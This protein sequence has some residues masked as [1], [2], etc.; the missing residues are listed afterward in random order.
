MLPANP[1]I[2]AEKALRSSFSEFCAINPLYI[3]TEFDFVRKRCDWRYPGNADP[4]V[5]AAW[6]PFANDEI[7]SAM[8][9]SISACA[10]KI[11]AAIT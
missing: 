4:F 6:T 8:K 9:F 5:T 7:I 10:K 2:A 3:F 11:D 1:F